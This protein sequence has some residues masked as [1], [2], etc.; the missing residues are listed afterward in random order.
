MIDFIFL[1]ELN[2]LELW[3]DDVGSAYLEAKPKEK[4]YI[5]AG[6][7]GPNLDH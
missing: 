6:L 7:L 4:V 1:A 5:V 3:G 2:G